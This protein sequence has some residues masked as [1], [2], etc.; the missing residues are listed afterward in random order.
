MYAEIILQKFT[1][2]PLS[3][4]Q[5]VFINRT[6]HEEPKFKRK[7]YYRAK[8][9]K[10]SRFESGHVEPAFKIGQGLAG[11]RPFGSHSNKPD[12]TKHSEGFEIEKNDRTQLRLRVAAFHGPMQ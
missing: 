2:G 9:I 11:Y 3:I 12:S 5:N 7:L 10:R 1:T 8:V 4:W 6:H